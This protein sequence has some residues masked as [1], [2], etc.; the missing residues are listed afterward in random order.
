MQYAICNMQYAICNMQYAICNMQ[1]AICGTADE[2]VVEN[3]NDKGSI[4]GL[5]VSTE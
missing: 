5:T 4:Y 2:A 1:Y 3:E